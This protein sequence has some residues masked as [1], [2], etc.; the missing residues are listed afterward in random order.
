M[1]TKTIQR[2]GLVILMVS[3][4][5]AC[6]P[7]G[8]Q[9]LVQDITNT[10][11]IVI[12]GKTSTSVVSSASATYS[13]PSSPGAQPYYVTHSVGDAYQ[14]PTFRANDQTQTPSGYKVFSSVQGE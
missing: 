2:I 14:Q 8:N 10:I 1:K 12:P 11:A 5:S 4:L 13:I 7:F 6:S 3:T 9:S